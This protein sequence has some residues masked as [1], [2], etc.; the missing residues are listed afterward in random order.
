MIYGY[1]RVSTNEQAEDGRSSIA[2]QERR[3]RAVATFHDYPEPT[4]VADVVTGSVALPVRQHGGNLWAGLQRGDTLIAS[5]LD[6]I[7][8][9]AEDALASARQL[10][11]RGIALIIADMGVEPVTGNGVSKLF[12]TMLAAFAEFE[13]W[14]IK[15]RMN[16][17][18]S[19]KKAKGGHIGGSAPYGFRV[20]GKGRE[21]S[22]VPIDA[23]QV[24]IAEARRMR[25]MGLTLRTISDRLADAGMH[26]RLGQKFTPVQVE[27][28]VK[29]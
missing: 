29:A 27:R 8:R 25:G 24:T 18:R 12:F 21:A 16:D 13:R 3:I 14:R 20:E 23:E 26:N 9:S 19:G 1:T 4:M 5:K 17:G 7:F 22:L 28:M 15:E 6:R 2:D 10:Q 11:E